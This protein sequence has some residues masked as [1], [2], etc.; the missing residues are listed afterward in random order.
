MKRE[1][2]LRQRFQEIRAS[3]IDSKDTFSW[4]SAQG[5]HRALG[6]ATRALRAQFSGRGNLV[7]LT[8]AGDRL[9]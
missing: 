5:L 4:A 1:M 6:A 9:A 7:L 8:S 2:R 3:A